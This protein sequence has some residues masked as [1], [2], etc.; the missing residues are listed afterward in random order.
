VR[1]RDRQRQRYTDRETERAL[2]ADVSETFGFRL[3]IGLKQFLVLLQGRYVYN[4]R[5]ITKKCQYDRKL[6]Y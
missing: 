3:Q 5:V 2:C 1:E 4:E 6:I